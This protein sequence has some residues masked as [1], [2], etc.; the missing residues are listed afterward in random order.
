MGNRVL[1]TLKI[2]AQF[3]AA[4]ALRD[5]PGDCRRLHGHNWKVETEVEAK[6]L[7]DIGIAIDFKAIKAATRTLADSLDNRF[8]NDIEPFDRINPSAENL[9]AW[10]YRQFENLE[11]Q[12]R[13]CQ[14][15]HDLGNRHRLRPLQGDRCSTRSL[16]QAKPGEGG[17]YV[18]GKTSLKPSERPDRCKSCPAKAGHQPEPS[19]AWSRSDPDCEAYT[20]GL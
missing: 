20:G 12:R 3:C 19:V 18:E 9:A 11:W 2:Q 15:R 7:N 4:H 14:R 8:L 13:Q 1:Y 17:S 16:R 6:V 10:F 5:Y